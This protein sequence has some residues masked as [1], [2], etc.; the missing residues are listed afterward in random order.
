[1]SGE[2]AQS[3]APRSIA[4][5]ALRVAGGVGLVYALAVVGIAAWQDRL[6]YFPEKQGPGGPADGSLQ[7]RDVDFVSADGTH[8]HGWFFPAKQ[9]RASLLHSHGNAGHIGHR[10]FLVRPLTQLGINVMLYDYRGYGRSDGSP[11]EEGLYQDAVAARAALGLQAEA[12]NHP[13]IY[14][15]ES[16]GGAVAAELAVRM[17]PDALVLQSTFTSLPDM[18]A[19][20]FPI[21]PARWLVKAKYRT[22]DKIP[23][24]AGFPV[25]VIHGEKDSLIPFAMGQRLFDAAPPATRHFLAVPGAD[26]NDVWDHGE[27]QIT[28][29]IGALLP[30]LAH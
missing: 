20:A 10:L 8:L 19:Q 30:G 21:L 14:Y 1:M 16:L 23:R 28:A 25:L 7:Y 24:F 9:P 12:S 3:L 5:A 18:A 17:P 13:V 22:L 26:H 6:I 29:A 27:T 11:S 15:G 2:G 4:R